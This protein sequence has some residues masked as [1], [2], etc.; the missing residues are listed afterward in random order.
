MTFEEAKHTKLYIGD[1]KGWT[2]FEIAATDQ[3][4]KWLDW[5]VGQTW[6]KMYTQFK[7]VKVYLD[8]PAI[9][10]EVARL[11]EVEGR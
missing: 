7:A 4:L 2:I 3:G 1:Y 5:L 11:L 10:A 6:F 9:S 8:D